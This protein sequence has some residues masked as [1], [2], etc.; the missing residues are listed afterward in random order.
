MLIR[1]LNRRNFIQILS[2]SAAAGALSACQEQPVAAEDNR[3]APGKLP[4]KPGDI[5]L[6]DPNAPVQVVE[7]ASMTCSHCAA[8]A[9]GDAAQGKEAVF[10]KIK[11]QYIETG[12][13]RYILREFPLDPFAAAAFLAM[14]CAVGDNPQRYYAVADLL[15]ERQAQWAFSTKE[16]AEITNN[17]AALMKETGLGRAQFDACISDEAQL[18]RVN[19]VQQ[20]A[21]ES[22]KVGSTPTFIINGAKYEGELEFKRFE[23][24]LAPL[25]KAS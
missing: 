19:A 12:R 1:S 14:R 18:R 25:L 9:V 20:E 23:E 11:A 8:F 13:V 5:A 2:L 16:G 21:A 10:P 22:Y 17:L 4:E 3:V 6:G 24:I 7:Y 15:F